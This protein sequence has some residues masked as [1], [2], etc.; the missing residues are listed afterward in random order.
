VLRLGRWALFEAQAPVPQRLLANYDRAV[1]EQA[2]F[3]ISLEP[4]GG[5]PTGRPTGPTFH[6]KLIETTR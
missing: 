1:V 2:T 5:S 3:G 6:A 4:A